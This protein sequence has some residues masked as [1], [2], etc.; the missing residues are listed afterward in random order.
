MTQ[1]FIGTRQDLQAFTQELGR[2]VVPESPAAFQQAWRMTG[3]LPQPAVFLNPVFPSRKAEWL[4]P[5]GDRHLAF[6]GEPTAAW[7]AWLKLHKR[8]P[9]R[10]SFSPEVVARLLTQGHAEANMP[11]LTPEAAAFVAEAFPYGLSAVQAFT[12]VLVAAELPEP[13]GLAAVQAI[14]PFDAGLVKRY[15]V[16]LSEFQRQLGRPEGLALALRVQ[17]KNA[18]PALH[19]LENVYCKQR[20]ELLKYMWMVRKAFDLKRYSARMALFLF[21][22]ACYQEA[23]CPSLATDPT[24]AW[25]RLTLRSRLWSIP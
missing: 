8:K 18:V 12:Q 10:I 7:K 6:E 11:K 17:E 9:E 14:W 22:W 13:V 21:A 4:T 15:D 2:W 3:L 20:P 16:A 24:S 25:R 5:R 1:V 23:Q 19:V